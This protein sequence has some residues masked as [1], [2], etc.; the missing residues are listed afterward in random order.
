MASQDIWQR[1]YHI[2]I[3][4]IV[5]K[6]LTWYIIMIIL[7]STD[8]VSHSIRESPRS[9]L[10]KTILEIPLLAYTSALSCIIAGK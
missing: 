9:T 10:L 2:R 6:G 8:V 3:S 1:L 7:L 4:D 5:H